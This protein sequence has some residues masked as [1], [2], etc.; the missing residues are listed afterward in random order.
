MRKEAVIFDLDGL[1][2]DSERVTFRCMAELARMLGREI[3]QA[4]YC[5]LLGLP[6]KRIAKKLRQHFGKDFP[7]DQFLD[8]THAAI[9]QDFLENG[10]SLKEG[11]PELL[12]FLQ[13][14]GFTM[15]LATSSNRARADAILTGKHLEGYFSA[16]ICGDEI[17]RGKPDPDVFLKACRK[18]GVA[19]EQAYV[20]EDSEMGLLA[21]YRAGID[22]IMVPD[23]AS[24]APEY[25]VKAHRVVDSLWEALELIRREAALPEEKVMLQKMHHAC[26]VCR[27]YEAAVH[28]YADILGFTIHRKSYS[29]E[30]G[31]Y[32]LELYLHGEYLIELFIQDVRHPEELTRAAGLGHLAFQVPDVARAAEYLAQEGVPASP[33]QQDQIT[34]KEYLFFYDPDGQKLELYQA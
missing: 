19:P 23:M 31:R 4:F 1:M 2:I 24:P 25:R 13:G 30:K 33:L 29:P 9:A 5:Q 11:L 16:S 10:V 12:D 26:I 21:A 6:A 34:G 32:K 17:A 3:D 7:A 20:L 14:A 22:C 15:I 8:D 27:D 18:A 28:F